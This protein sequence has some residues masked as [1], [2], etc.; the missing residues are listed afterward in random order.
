MNYIKQHWFSIMIS[1]FMSYF[2]LIFILVVV[3]PQ[4]D[5]L[6]RGFIPCSIAQSDKIISCENSG[7]MCILNGIIKG[8]L[9][10][11]KVFNIGIYNFITAKQPRPWSNYMFTPELKLQEN[12]TKD[13]DDGLKE[14]L[15]QKPTLITDIEKVKQKN[16]ELQKKLSL[17]N[18]EENDER[19]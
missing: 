8:N 19:K 18:S 7:A 13:Q 1:A 12:A 3:S 17:N 6:N 11:M 16:L 2:L 10:Y 9:C 4:K 15:K 14:L 5:D